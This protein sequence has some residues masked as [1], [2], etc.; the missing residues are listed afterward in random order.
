MLETGAQPPHDNIEIFVKFI[1]FPYGLPTITKANDVT[2]KLCNWKSFWK[3]FESKGKVT[4]FS[5]IQPCSVNLLSHIARSA[6]AAYICR[7]ADL[8]Q[9]YIDSPVNHGQEAYGNAHVS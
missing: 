1:C 3:I 4:D 6:Y 9:F 7:N 8:L 2:V 5:L